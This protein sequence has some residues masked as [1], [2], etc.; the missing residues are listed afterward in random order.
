VSN[1]DCTHALAHLQDYLKQEITPDLA[2][3]IKEHLNR[4]RRCF[5]HARFEANFLVMLETRAAKGT[6]P[7]ELRAR[8]LAKL[9]LE[10]ETED[11]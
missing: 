4:C 2:R 8:I 3:E 1:V 9:R 11:A 10:A 6:C 5:R 7:G